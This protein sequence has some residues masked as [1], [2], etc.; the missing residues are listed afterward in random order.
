[1]IS[2]YFIHFGGV[3]I[4]RSLVTVAMFWQ[5]YITAEEIYCYNMMFWLSYNMVEHG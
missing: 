4:F 2:S 3:N 1:M 5:N